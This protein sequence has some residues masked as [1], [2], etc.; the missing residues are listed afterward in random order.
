MGVLAVALGGGGDGGPGVDADASPPAGG[1]DLERAIAGYGAD[2]GRETALYQS[3]MAESLE[4]AN[5]ADRAAAA[6]TMAY[7][8]SRQAGSVRVDDRIGLLQRKLRKHRGN[9][10]VDAFLDEST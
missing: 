10:A 9:A 1:A 7:R 3:W 2:T 4:Q 6:A 8:L 5:E